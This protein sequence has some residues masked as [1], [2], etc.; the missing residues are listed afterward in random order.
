VEAR[1]SDT[2][3]GL[4]TGDLRVWFKPSEPA[5]SELVLL[6]GARN[7]DSSFWD[8]LGSEGVVHVVQWVYLDPLEVYENGS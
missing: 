5:N 3:D 7:E 8:V 4:T 6:L 2:R 1:L